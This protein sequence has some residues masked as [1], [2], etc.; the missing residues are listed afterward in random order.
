MVNINLATGQQHTETREESSYKKRLNLALLVI[1]LIGGVYAGIFFYGRSLD[2]KIALADNQSA[3]AIATL[4][5]G[6]KS[7]VFDYQNRLS[8][9]KS[10]ANQKSQS[11]EVLRKME[12][13]VLPGVYLQSFEFVG[14]G[15]G[16]V[17]LS[18]IADNYDLVAKQIMNFKSSDYFSSA[19]NERSGIAEGGKVSFDITL[20][21]K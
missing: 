21:I 13:L 10:L 9:A 18:A 20:I 15:S 4:D 1:V 6:G 5:S 19:V 2:N 3:A 8:A 16:S 17:K 14:D 11:L 12:G 7:A